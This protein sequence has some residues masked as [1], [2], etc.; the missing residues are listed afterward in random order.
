MSPKP[1]ISYEKNEQRDLDGAKPLGI[2][3]VEQP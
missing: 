2:N 3:V 1:K